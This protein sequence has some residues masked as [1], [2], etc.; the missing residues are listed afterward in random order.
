MRNTTGINKFLASDSTKEN[1]KEENVASSLSDTIVSVRGPNNEQSVQTTLQQQQLQVEQHA[2]SLSSSPCPTSMLFEDPPQPHENEVV[3]HNKTPAPAHDMNINANSSTV[4]HQQYSSLNR[5]SESSIHDQGFLACNNLA[6]SEVSMSNNSVEINN[7]LQHNSSSYVTAAGLCF[8]QAAMGTYPSRIA[9]LGNMQQQ[10]SQQL[11][12]NQPQATSQLYNAASLSTCNTKREFDARMIPRTSMLDYQQH[13]L[14]DYRLHNHKMLNNVSNS[15]VVKTLDVSQGLYH[16]TTEHQQQ[17]QHAAQQLCLQQQQT[18]AQQHLRH[19]YPQYIHGGSVAFSSSSSNTCNPSQL[20]AMQ[21]QQFE[22]FPC[23]EVGV[24]D[25]GG[26]GNIVSAASDACTGS[27]SNTNIDG[28]VP[29]SAG[30]YQ[31]AGIDLS[32]TKSEPS[33]PRD[34]TSATSSHTTNN[35]RK[36]VHNNIWITL[37]ESLYIE[38]FLNCIV[39]LFPPPPK[40]KYSCH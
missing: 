9:S 11:M 22:E 18:A 1:E 6:N 35:K 2:P 40:M 24:E 31:T 5:A 33:S 37:H 29:R 8:N 27:S 20:L 25:A 36:R 32:L 10:H 7:T 14:D 19:H 12:F 21:H 13:S 3:T 39:L 16:T 23:D 26:G 17:Q 4:N 28:S 38:I 15:Q 34:Y 30:C